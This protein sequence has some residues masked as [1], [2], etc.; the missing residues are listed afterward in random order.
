MCTQSRISSLSTVL[1]KRERDSFHQKH[2][3]NFVE[4]RLLEPLFCKLLLN[5]NV[6]KNLDLKSMKNRLKIHKTGV[7]KVEFQHKVSIVKFKNESYTR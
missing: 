5:F 2:E 3:I 7:L 1:V 4:I 6:Y